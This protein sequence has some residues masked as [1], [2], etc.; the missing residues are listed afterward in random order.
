MKSQNNKLL[1]AIIFVAL[2]I[3][4]LSSS[5]CLTEDYQLS[6]FISPDTCGDCHSEIFDQWQNSMHN[7][8]QK[9]PIY[10]NVAKFILNGLTD[11]DEIAEAESC[12][13]CHV[14]VGFITGY[15]K[16]SSDDKKTIPELAT[17][18]IQCDYCHSAVNAKKMYNNDLILEPGNGEDEPGIKRGPFSDSDS[19]FHE[20]EFSKFHTSSEICGTCHNV[21]HVVFKTNLETTYEEWKNGPYNSLDQK[22]RITCQGC[23]MYQRPGIPATGSTERPENPGTASDDG[24]V[25][26][27]IFTHYFVGANSFVPGQ[28]DDQIKRKMAEDRLKNSATISLDYKQITKGK[29]II[30][31]KNTGAGHYLPTGLTDIRQMWLEILIKDENKRVIYSSGKLDKDNYIPSGTIIFNT[32]FGDGKGNPV[33][34][35]AKAREILKDKRI[36]PLKTVSETIT[37]PKRDWNSLAVN[38]KLLYRSAPQKIMDMVSVKGK[39]KLPIITI[40]EAKKK[41]SGAV[42]SE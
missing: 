24:P 11:K 29:L 30:K 8:S 28:F 6:R 21:K 12:V 4:L 9:D 34:N 1:K 27:H 15:P 26:N 36:P 23:H 38:V 37:L 39:N 3:L 31:I 22:K 32:V 42:K 2:I 40:S 16:K 18:G 33:I 19:D 20:T 17:H 10:L 13:K 7:L 14:P 25:R 5:S 41:S 35:I